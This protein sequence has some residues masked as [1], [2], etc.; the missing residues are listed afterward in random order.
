MSIRAFPALVG[1]VAALTFQTAGAQPVRVSQV[2]GGHVMQFGTPG[3]EWGL[4]VAVGPS[5]SVYVVGQTNGPLG[6]QTVTPCTEPRGADNPCHDGY[7][8][9]FDAAGELEWVRLLGGG[10]DDLAAKVV[11]DANE[12]I[13]IAGVWDGTTSSEFL[14]YVF[15]ARFDAS[16]KQVWLKKVDRGSASELVR[17]KD[18]KLDA[19]GRTLLLAGE[20]RGDFDGA[21]HIGKRVNGNA[22]GFDVF[23]SRFS[24]DGERLWTSFLG[25]PDKSLTAVANDYASAVASDGSG[26]VYFSG[27]TAG[28][29]QSRAWAPASRPFLMK[30]SE[31]GQVQSVRYS[32]ARNAASVEHLA[33]DRQDAVYQLGQVNGSAYR[34]IEQGLDGIDCTLAKVDRAGKALWSVQFGSGRRDFPTGL[35]VDGAGNIVVT[36]VRGLHDHPDFSLYRFSP[37]G[38]LQLRRELGTSSDEES[39]GVALDEPRG[40]AYLTGY[41]TGDFSGKRGATADAFLAR[42]PVDG[43]RGR[44]SLLR[45]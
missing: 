23:V 38:D 36:F 24:L 29:L 34:A 32:V 40:V 12:S 22:N 19:A 20:T 28:D 26:A 1:L 3:N 17:V 5:G 30:L 9:K 45:E 8:A 6:G 14:Q 43:K 18:F 7:L 39:A 21:V 15:L 31:G 41:T 42:F 44:D 16:G 35:A 13:F 11:V 10:G 33:V 4:G 37:N 25:V 2:E 27:T